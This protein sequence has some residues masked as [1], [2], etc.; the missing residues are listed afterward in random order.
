M[1]NPFLEID[2]RLARIERA[3]ALAATADKKEDTGL[4]EIL[5]LTQAVE[6]T[7]YSRDYLYQLNSRGQVPSIPA[8]RGSKLRFNKKIL[9][10][11]L[12][13]GAPKDSLAISELLKVR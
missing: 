3:L 12:A 4:P 6:L 2:E 9:L 8:V 13:M 5:N 1:N 10:M 11:W 7:G